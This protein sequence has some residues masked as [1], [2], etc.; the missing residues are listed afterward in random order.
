MI[1]KFIHNIFYA[2]LNVLKESFVA[3][4]AIL[5][6]YQGIAIALPTVVEKTAGLLCL[7][8][9]IFV[10]IIYGFYRTW[11]LNQV[12]IRIPHTNTTISILFGD[13]FKQEGVRVIPVNEFFDSEIGTPVSE[14]SLH[15]ILI[16][17]HLQGQS[18]D[19]LVDSQLTNIE[20]NKIREKTKGKQIRYP[21]GTTVRVETDGDYLVFA[22]SKTRP[23]TC[24]AYCDVVIMHNALN[25]LWKK[26]RDTS[27][28]KSI[29]IPLVGS[30]QSGTGLPTRDLLNLIILSAITETKKERIAEEIKII[31]QEHYFEKLDLR[32]IKQYWEKY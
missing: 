21:I 22:S 11:K 1:K 24:K 30:G 20:S 2:R 14:K 13:L 31:L 16:Q 19:A 23:D 10:S 25:G 15:G 26:G 17:K 28:G 29:N 3:L 5:C 18:F 6:L 8:V 32:S 27:G 4:G 12:N 9:F 7:F